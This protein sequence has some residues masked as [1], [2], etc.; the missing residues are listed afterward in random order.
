MILIQGCEFIP[1]KFPIIGSIEAPDFRDVGDFE[2]WLR[3]EHIPKTKIINIQDCP[4]RDDGLI[5]INKIECWGV[6]GS[7]GEFER[8]CFVYPKTHL[9]NFPEFENFLRGKIF[10][11]NHFSSDS[12]LS[13]GE[14]LL[15]ANLKMR[16][17]RAVTE[18]HTF[19]IKPLNQNWPYPDLLYTAMVNICPVFDLDPEFKNDSELRHICYQVLAREGYFIYEYF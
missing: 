3:R 15:W 12:T 5:D 1:Q 14:V 13:V 7:N 8:C 6:F 11:H 10:S 18:N 2:S 9:D 17:I 19:I 16:E 4:D